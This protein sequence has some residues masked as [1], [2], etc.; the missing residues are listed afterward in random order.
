M[1]KYSYK[2]KIK[3]IKYYLENKGGY[4]KIHKNILNA[5]FKADKSNE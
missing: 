4:G 2:L 3:V 1:C 5:N